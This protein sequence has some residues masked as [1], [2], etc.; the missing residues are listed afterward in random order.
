MDGDGNRSIGLLDLVR[1]SSWL[2]PQ[3]RTSVLEVASYIE[4]H[5]Q[6]RFKS[7]QSYYDLLHQARFSWKKSKARDVDRP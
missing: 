6:V 3:G 1:F 2:K 5:F 4:Q 7:E